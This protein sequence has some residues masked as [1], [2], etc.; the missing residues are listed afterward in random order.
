MEPTNDMNIEN[1]GK[2]SNNENQRI[3]ER[4]Q[5]ESKK[6]FQKGCRYHG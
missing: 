1:K 6:Y 4:A 3:T 2:I 5:S